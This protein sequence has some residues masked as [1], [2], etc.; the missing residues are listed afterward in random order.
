[1]LKRIKRDRNN[2]EVEKKPQD[3]G[4]LWWL[5]GLIALAMTLLAIYR[6]FL[7]TPH[8]PIVLTVYMVAFTALIF[9]YVIYNRGFSRRNLTKEMLNDAW[10]DEEKEAFL[11]NG[12]ERMR[13]S[14]WM[15]VLILAIGFTFAF[16][17]LELFVLPYFQ[18]MFFK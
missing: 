8:F 5:L 1:M 12:R 7:T 15:L 3:N 9:I 14:K 6:F 4:K 16:D 2:R 11:E 17:M 18:N 10:S 13:K